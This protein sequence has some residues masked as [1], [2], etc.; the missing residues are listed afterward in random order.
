MSLSPLNTSRVFSHSGGNTTVINSVNVLQ[1][2][3]NS[4]PSDALTIAELRLCA[5]V[6]KEAQY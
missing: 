6:G 4:V 1:C 3:S 2:S 5:D